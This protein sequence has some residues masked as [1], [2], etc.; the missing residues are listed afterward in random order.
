LLTE[1]DNI[2]SEIEHASMR[3]SELQSAMKDLKKKLMS[4]SDRKKRIMRQMD[5]LKEQC[6]KGEKVCISPCARKCSEASSTS[7]HLFKSTVAV[8][9]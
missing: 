1:K 8:D 4:E 3:K 7:P 2:E 6:A 5:D 9:M